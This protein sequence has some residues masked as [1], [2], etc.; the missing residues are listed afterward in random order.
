M[1]ST[2]LNTRELDD[3]SAATMKSMSLVKDSTL[4]KVAIVCVDI[5]K[6]VRIES[7]AGQC[8][9]LYHQVKQKQKLSRKKPDD[10]VECSSLA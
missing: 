3:F 6:K 2:N 5:I 8:R 9:A 1:A 4:L 10:E 7:I